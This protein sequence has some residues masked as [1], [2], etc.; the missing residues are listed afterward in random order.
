MSS[1]KRPSYINESQWRLL[2]ALRRC[3]IIALGALEEYMGIERSIVPRH[4]RE[5]P[6]TPK[7]REAQIVIDG[8]LLGVLTLE[9]EE[10]DKSSP[11]RLEA[12]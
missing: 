2:D 1:D 10:R 6:K 9:P 7:K 3:L 5:A 8:K 12:A 11:K 4:K